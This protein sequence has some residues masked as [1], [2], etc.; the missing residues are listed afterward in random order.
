MLE[1]CV[2]WPQELIKKYKEKGY[3][4]DR[5]IGEVMQEAFERYGDKAA[6]IFE[7][8]TVTYRVLGERVRRLVLHF[9]QLGLRPYDRMVLQIHNIP[10]MIYVYCAAVTVGVIPVMALPPHREAEIGYFAEFAEAKAYAIPN[11][12]RKFDYQSMAKDLRAKIPS[13]E[14]I[15]VAGE[16]V[17]EGFYSIKKMLDKPIEQRVDTVTLRDSRPDPM[18]PAVFQ[19]SGGTTGI[20]KFIPRTHNDYMYNFKRCA[21]V[22]HVDEDTVMLFSIPITHNFSVVSPGFQGILANGGKAVLAP[23]ARPDDILPLIEKEKVTVIPAV[24]AIVV[25]LLNSPNRA[26]YDLSSLKLIISGGSKLAPEV[27]RRIEPELG[28][29]YQEV[30]G[31]AEGLNCWTLTTD[32]EEVR[33]NTQGR[34]MCPDDEIKVVDERGKEVQS[35]EV[36]ELFVRGPYTIRGYY[37]SPERN[38][39]SFTE[40]GFYKTGDLVRMH[41]SGNVIVE[42]RKKDTINRGGE[43]ISAEEIENHIIAHTVVENCACV[44]MPDPALEERICC[45]VVCKKGKGLTLEELTEFLLQE[46]RIARFKLPERLEVVESLPL[47]K[48]G[49]VDKNALREMI[50]EKLQQEGRI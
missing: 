11:E 33:L 6:I 39:E 1:G 14:F 7:G 35:G 29:Q 38:K 2:P 42:G 41:P 36:G 19:L 49:K 40:D 18:E 48:V 50:R 37:R 25:G 8:Q 34:P 45:F 27:K 21:E 44:G 47:T 23:S 24:P 26:K 31:M 10:E 30:L 13:L 15:F 20:P 12:F 28:C 46:R 43:K 3:W 9:I 4:E 5:A 22:I 17:H 16:D 32:P